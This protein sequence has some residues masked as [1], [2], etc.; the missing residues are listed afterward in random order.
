MQVKDMNVG[1]PHQ[2]MR[3]FQRLGTDGYKRRS[4][5]RKQGNIRNCTVMSHN[6]SS[7][8]SCANLFNNRSL[9]RVEATHMRMRMEAPACS[10]Y[11]PT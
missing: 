2:D 7:S 4:I 11:I 9:G 3:I 8:G 5:A 10:L 6:N 1:C